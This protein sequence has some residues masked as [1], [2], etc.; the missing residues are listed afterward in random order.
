MIINERENMTSLLPSWLGRLRDAAKW[1]HGMVKAGHHYG[2]MLAATGSHS[3][4][5]VVE[6][7]RIQDR[8]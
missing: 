2:A 3:E 5:K 8:D 6:E 1:C 4:V 7:E